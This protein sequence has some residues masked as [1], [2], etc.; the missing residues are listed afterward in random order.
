MRDL[1]VIGSDMKLLLAGGTVI[2]AARIRPAIPVIAMVQEK[3]LGRRLSLYW[4]V[5]P[6]YVDIRQSVR[7]HRESKAPFSFRIM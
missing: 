7:R 6:A 5:Y 3:W 4:G 2:R 1:G